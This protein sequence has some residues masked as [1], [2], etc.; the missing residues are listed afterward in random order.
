M[1]ELKKITKLEESSRFRSLFG[2]NWKN[3]LPLSVIVNSFSI[4][5]AGSAS[6]TGK[7]WFLL[8]RQIN[9]SREC[10]VPVEAMLIWFW[11]DRTRLIMDLAGSSVSINYIDSFRNNSISV[12]VSINYIRDW[13]A[14]MFISGNDLVIWSSLEINRGM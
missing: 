6:A 7:P 4:F 8:S 3:I 5:R 11:Q 12:S 9:C 13:S 2:P 14:Q 10:W 1:S